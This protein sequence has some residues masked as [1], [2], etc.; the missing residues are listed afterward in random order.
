[1]MRKFLRDLFSPRSGASETPRAEAGI[2]YK[3]YTI[4]AAPEHGPAGW[5]VAGTISK[6]I[7]GGRRVHRLDRADAAPDREAIVAMTIEK[8][9][10]VIDEQG[11]RI[12]GD[13]GSDRPS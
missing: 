7:G 12:F 5:R 13:A 2:E 1:M 4:T 6:E 3:S 9:K 11:D 10:R 8:A